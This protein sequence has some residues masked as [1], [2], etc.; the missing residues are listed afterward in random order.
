MTR[1]LRHGRR[2]RRG[3]NYSL[4]FALS[5]FVLL[6]FSALVVDIGY[7]RASSVQLQN[8]VDATVLGAANLLDYSDEGVVAARAAAIEIAS[9]NVVDGEPLELDPNELNDPEGEIVFG[10]W[11]GASFTASDD[12]GE[13]NA[14]Q[15][16]KHLPLDTRISLLTFGVRSINV[17]ATSTAVL[18]DAE[19]AGAVD[20]MIPL[21]LADCMLD[22]YTEEELQQIDLALNPAGIDN[23]GW[24]RPQASPNASWL[25]GQIEDCEGEGEIAVGQSLGLQNGVV[26]SAMSSLASAINGSDESWDTVNWGAQP[27]QANRS[28]VSNYGNVFSGPI[29]LFDGGSEYCEGGGGSFN[30]FETITGFV[31]ASVYDVVTSGPAAGKN[32]SVR[33]DFSVD[34]TFGTEGGGT[35]AGVVYVPPATLVQ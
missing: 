1:H 28:A 6:G 21:A 23:V 20:C 11:D 13:V 19:G 17:N 24:A 16:N 35:N 25:R 29:A 15:V 32:V 8:I 22:L 31:W 7:Q 34:H 30:G 3:G 33:L 26:S 9:A 12:A 4:I 10:V 5:F 2:A 14:L 18:P 27:S